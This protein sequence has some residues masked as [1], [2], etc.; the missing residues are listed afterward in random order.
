MS[1]RIKKKNI[2]TQ[3]H[4]R[5]SA[6]IEKWAEENLNAPDPNDPLNID[7]WAGESPP[8]T[9]NGVPYEELVAQREEEEDDDEDS[10]ELI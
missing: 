6:K 7:E 1:R 10:T 9:I 4:M 5:G 3:L 2:D 8:H